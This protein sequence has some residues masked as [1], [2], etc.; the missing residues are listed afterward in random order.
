MR[1]SR[2]RHPVASIRSSR[3]KRAPLLALLAVMVVVLVPAVGSARSPYATDWSNKYPSSSS[4]N[5][6]GC[7]LCHGSSTSTW[8]PYGWAIKQQYDVSG[9]IV[10]AI[11][12]AE[13]VNSD[14]D[15]TVSSNLKEITANAQPGWTYGAHNDVYDSN[16]SVT[17]NNP[18][19]VNVTGLIDPVT[20]VAVSDNTF[21]PSDLSIAMGASVRW[22]RAALSTGSHSVTEVGGIFTSGAPTTGAI[23][24]VRNFSAGTFH[25]WCSVHTTA[26][27]GYVRV[28]PKTAAAPTGLPFTVTWATATSNTGTLFD[29]QYK[30]GTGSWVDWK[31][32]TATFKGVF[33]KSGSPV[34]VVAGTK[35]SFRVHS[36]SGVVVSLWSPTKAFTP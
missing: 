26:M 4:D 13:T 36:Q 10:A 29:V 5:N 6:A 1:Y 30:I 18:V 15:P 12:S 28:K 19:P 25:Y 7:Q 20:N 31:V 2:A 17:H 8:N 14:A 22:S 21:T 16:G 32:D 24:Y 11:A 33:G 3:A 34:T 27:Q 9:D 35:Y 23:D